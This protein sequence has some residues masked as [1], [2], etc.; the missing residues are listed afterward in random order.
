MFYG[1]RVTEIKIWTKNTI[2]VIVGCILIVCVCSLI[3]RIP[4]WGNI[5]QLLAMMFFSIGIYGFALL[6]L[7]NTVACDIWRRFCKRFWSSK[8]WEKR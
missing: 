3:L 6:I 2:S 7:Q 8:R 4:N 1:H 5:S